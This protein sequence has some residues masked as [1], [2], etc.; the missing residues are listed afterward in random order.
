MIARLA[1]R[2]REAPIGAGLCRSSSPIHCE[3]VTM[4]P[5]KEPHREEGEDSL[6]A[7]TLKEEDHNEP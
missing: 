5:G 4:P 1:F 3:P 7:M 2:P 6:W